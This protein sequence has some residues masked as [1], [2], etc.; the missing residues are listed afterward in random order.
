M[1][2]LQDIADAVGVTRMTASRVLNSGYVPTRSDGVR[3]ARRIRKVAQELGYR[4]NAAARSTRTGRFNCLAILSPMSVG[5]FLPPTLLIGLDMAMRLRN[6][7][8][9]ISDLPPGINANDDTAPKF[10]RELLADG[11]LINFDPQKMPPGLA[12][13]I[14][15]QNVPSIWINMPRRYDTIQPDDVQGAAWATRTLIER[16]ARRLLMVTHADDRAQGLISLRDREQGC[17]LA[18]EEAGLTVHVLRQPPGGHEHET[19]QELIALF[20][21]PDRPDAVYGYEALEAGRAMLAAAYAGLRVPDDLQ[22][23]VTSDAP[24]RHAGLTIAT[25]QIPFGEIGQ[26]AV[27]MLGEKVE[28]PDTPLTPRVVKYLHLNPGS[29]LS[30]A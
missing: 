27:D 18:A 19:L 8:L 28:A 30:G 13:R 2:T 25:A 20:R 10:L 4:P 6:L 26:E 29:T 11:L 14:E 16:G 7:H 24:P 17:R 9:S 22:V 1:A 5:G 23:I 3:R 15:Q 12:D 21:S